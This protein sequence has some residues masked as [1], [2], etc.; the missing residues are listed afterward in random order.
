[1]KFNRLKPKI[2]FTIDAII[3]FVTCY[4]IYY[5]IPRCEIQQSEFDFHVFLSHIFVIIFSTA[6]SQFIMKSYKNIWKYAEY[7]EYIK[8]MLGVILGFLIYFLTN[9]FLFSKK[10]SAIFS[11]ASCSVS[12]L[13][14]LLV[15]FLYKK[16]RTKLFNM[17]RNKL[18]IAIIGAGGAGVLL[19]NEILYNKSTNYSVRCFIDDDPDKIGKKIR[20]I[21]VYGPIDC[22]NDIIKEIS[23]SEVIVAIPSLTE[24]RK[25]E[26]LEIVTKADVKVKIL[27]DLISILQN[28]SNLLSSVRDFKIE[29]LIGR[30][31]ASFD[32]S[33]IK[34]YL[35]QKT[36]MVTGGGGSIGS[37][38]CRQIAKSNPKRL[39]IIDNYENNAY[40]IQQELCAKYKDSLNLSVEIASVQDKEK[41]DILFE[42]YRPEIIFHAAAHK[43]VPFMEDC[44]DEA[45]KNNI[46]GT[47]HTV[48][49]AHRYHAKKFVLISTDKAVNPASMMGASKRVSEMIVQ[50]MKEV[51]A[52]SYVTVRFGNVLGSNGSVI[53]LFK[54]QIQQGGPVTITDKR[55]YRY[56]MTISEAAQLVLRACTMNSHSETYV[57]D[58]G[59]PINILSLAENL[60]RLMGYIPY[61]E[62]PIV[63]IGMRPGEKLY[64]EL[65]MHNDDL[66]ETENA[67]IFIEKH[68]TISQE[69]IETILEKLRKALET[70][71]MEKIKEALMEAVPTFQKNS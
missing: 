65:L 33:E 24:Q 29:E 9:Y 55:A 38:L 61:T 56:F 27:Q 19:F 44:T 71:D 69:E 42:K 51:S 50:S 58:M 11:I 6:L 48:H 22:F 4:I 40:D 47:Y 31:S 70:K 15:R 7:L 39:I 54:R 14:M 2:L 17:T 28:G 53:P 35:N 52:T 23:V 64:E 21:M 3:V 34:S 26:I 49:A 36:I 30:Q 32:E 67:K 12:I 10:T 59:Q 18:P 25:K 16:Y 66:S 45:I 57:L 13:L 60:I 37:E 41:I 62:I 20:N 8:F 63:E 1:M 46:F 43:H 68:H 5:L